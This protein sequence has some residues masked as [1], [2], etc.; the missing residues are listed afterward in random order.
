[1]YCP[2]CGNEIPVELKYCNRCGANLTF[3]QQSLTTVVAPPVR[4]II[5]SIFLFLTIVGGL[6]VIFGAATEFARQGVAG[7]AIAWMVLFST[8]TLL[9]CIGL[10]IRFVTKMMTMNREIGVSQP[11]R[12]PSIE[13]RP[14]PQQHLPPPRFEPVPSVTENTTRTFTP[15]Y[16]EPADR[17]TR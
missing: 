15:I 1:M 7:A 4:L 14:T 9:G 16:T 8:A 3:T 10:F 6:G 2:S 5:P 11:V 17:G 12:Q 13:Q